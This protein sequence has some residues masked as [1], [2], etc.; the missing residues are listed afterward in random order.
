M[1]KRLGEEFLSLSVECTRLV[2]GFADIHAEEN[3]DGVILRHRELLEAIEY[4]LV[5]VAGVGTFAASTHVTRRPRD[6]GRV[7]IS[8]QRTSWCR[9]ATLPD[10]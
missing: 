2:F 3:V 5:L 10:H 8:C 1:W 6:S 7:P 4:V 9:A